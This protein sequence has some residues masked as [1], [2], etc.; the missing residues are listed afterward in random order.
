MI[1]LQML[2]ENTLNRED[3]RELCER[4]WPEPYAAEAANATI[5]DGIV[6]PQSQIFLIYDNFRRLLGITGYFEI[7]GDVA[8][9][10]WTGVLPEFRRR[11]IFL[12]AI[13]LLVRQLR[14]ANPNVKKLVE[15][16]PDNEYGKSIMNA[17][18]V[19][20]FVYDQEFPV[21]HGE[22][23]DWNVLPYIKHF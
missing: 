2:T 10:R 23:T 21:P 8:Y 9:L 3:I 5:S 4:I 16:V 15:L 19:S 12:E 11:G 17:F 7:E 20:G 6:D 1:Y 14:G 13:R 22:A 18:V